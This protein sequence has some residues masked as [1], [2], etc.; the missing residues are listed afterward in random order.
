MGS[1]DARQP[2]PGR[3]AE[4]PETI[5]HRYI[6]MES[7]DDEQAAKDALVE[8]VADR[9]RLLYLVQQF[10]QWD[11]LPGRADGPFWMREADEVLSGKE[12]VLTRLSDDRDRLAGEVDGWRK[13]AARQLEE[14]TVSTRQYAD[15]NRRF[16]AALEGIADA[17]SEF[18]LF[19]RAALDALLPRMEQADRWKAARIL[20]ASE[21]DWLIGYLSETDEHAAVHARRACAALTD[22]KEAG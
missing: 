22:S 7:D 15:E 18:A 21:L 4:T 9:D 14:F 11:D 20:A 13:L 8:L 16:R 17:D 10:R 5:L 2:E 1:Q 12:N 6:V 3:E 19:A